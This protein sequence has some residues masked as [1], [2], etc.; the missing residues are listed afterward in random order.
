MSGDEA[1]SA[2][3]A[4][5][6]AENIVSTRLIQAGYNVAEPRIPCQYDLIVDIDGNLTKTQVK[7][8]FED[9]REETLRV[10]MM[11]SVHK[12][13]TKYE[14]VKY[15]SEQVDAFAIYDPINDLVYWLWFD[16]APATELRRKYNSLLAHRL[17]CKL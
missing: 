12:G 2:N 5:A 14:S 16:E 1:L 9:S 4:G 17:D 7:R 10:N 11:G 15:D 13:Q 8:G 3:R 6:V